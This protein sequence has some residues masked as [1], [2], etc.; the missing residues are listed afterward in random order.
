MH[1]RTQQH[2][3]W[4]PVQHRQW[5]PVQHRQW[6]PV[7]HWQRAP[8]QHQKWAPVQHWQRAPVQHQK[9]A[10][11][12]CTRGLLIWQPQPRSGQARTSSLYSCTSSW[13]FRSATRPLYTQDTRSHAW[14]ACSSV[15]YM[16]SWCTCSPGAHH[17]AQPSG[18]SPGQ[19]SNLDFAV[20]T[21]CAHFLA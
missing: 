10:P 18:L 19:T 17:P 12:Q 20:G 2:R 14:A 13:K 9:W 21:H 6:A 3:Q 11:V 16:P 1:S 8:V 15:S 5:A 7:Q 4:A